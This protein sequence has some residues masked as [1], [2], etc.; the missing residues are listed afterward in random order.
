MNTVLPK[1]ILA[2]IPQFEDTTSEI[3]SRIRYARDGLWEALL[4]RV[5]GQQEQRPL[6]Q[7][8]QKTIEQELE[9]DGRRARKLCQAGASAKALKSLGGGMADG[10]AEVREC[11]A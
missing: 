4:L 8:E 1:L 2:P 11:W 9:A 5:A 10:P 7:R 3:R 6:T